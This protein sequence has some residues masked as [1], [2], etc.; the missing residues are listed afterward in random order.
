MGVNTYLRKYKN[1]TATM[2]IIL[3]TDNVFITSNP[4]HLIVRVAK[5]AIFPPI[6]HLNVQLIDLCTPELS[7]LFNAQNLM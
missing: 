1:R 2:W 5:P 6:K 7:L 4:F 3:I